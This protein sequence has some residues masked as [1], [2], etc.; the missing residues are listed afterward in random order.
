M[1]SS[2]AKNGW[3]RLR[4]GEKE[5]VPISSKAIQNIEFR[6][7]SNKIQKIK[8]HQQSFFKT[9]TGRD[10]LSMRGKKKLSFQSIQN[11]TGIGNSK[12]IAKNIKKTKNIIKAS[13]QAKTGRDRVRMREKKYSCSDPF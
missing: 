4:M 8:K 12:K 7:N 11:R 5:I 1:A 10:R 2:D 9:K 6:K 3:D 13:F